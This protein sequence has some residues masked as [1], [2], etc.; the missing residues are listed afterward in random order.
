MNNIT[1]LCA[2]GRRMKQCDHWTTSDCFACGKEDTIYHV[3][4]CPER[5]IRW[6]LAL[7]SIE[8]HLKRSDIEPSTQDTML[9]ILSRI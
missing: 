2:V 5:D 8:C 7:Q 6:H 3:W 1:G 4:R 9:E